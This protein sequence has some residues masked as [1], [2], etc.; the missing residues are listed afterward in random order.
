MARRRLSDLL[1]EEANKPSE[2][3]TAETEVEPSTDES[4]AEALDAAGE[5]IASD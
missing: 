1:R 5:T 2:E 3:T 4:D